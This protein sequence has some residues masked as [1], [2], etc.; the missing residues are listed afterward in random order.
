[1]KLPSIVLALVPTVAF[2]DPGHLL[3]AGGHDHWLAAAA[4]AAA[5]AGALW[6]ARKGRPKDAASEQ[7]GEAAGGATAQEG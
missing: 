7:D 2:A 1:M 5:L 4:A 3:G 6:G